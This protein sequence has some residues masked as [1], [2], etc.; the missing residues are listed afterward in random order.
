MLK[1]LDFVVFGVR[2]Q[3]NTLFGVIAQA[4][5]DRAFQQLNLPQKC[6]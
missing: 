3:G 2:N 5:Q 6:G 4:L 1:I